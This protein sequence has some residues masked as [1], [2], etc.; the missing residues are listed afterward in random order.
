MF[1]QLS[2]RLQ[3]VLGEIRSRGKLSE[4]DVKKALREV[5]LAL[6]EADVNFKVVKGFTDSL[7]E[8]LDG[9]E[10]SHALNPG[11]TVVKGLARITGDLQSL[12]KALILADFGDLV[13]SPSAGPATLTVNTLTL[14]A[15][16]R[17]VLGKPGVSQ[18]AS[19][20]FV[21][22]AEATPPTAPFEPTASVAPVTKT[23][24]SRRQKPAIEP[25]DDPLDPPF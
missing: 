24:R 19:Q 22:T 3:G 12:G 14:S 13:I 18:S 11:Q 9:A 10:V 21:T 15:S 7:R 17:L 25:V 16:A 5:R 8:R 2:D 6:L 4:D 1:D 20:G 23:S